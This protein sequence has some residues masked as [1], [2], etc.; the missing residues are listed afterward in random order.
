MDVHGNEC[1]WVVINRIL[2]KDGSL[3]CHAVAH[4]SAVV[5]DSDKYVPG[6]YHSVKKWDA[7]WEAGPHVNEGW[8]KSAMSKNPI[9][10][11]ILK[12]DGNGCHAIIKTHDKATGAMNMY[13]IY[14]VWG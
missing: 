11:G 14:A 13:E 3:R 1:G 6:D 12:G 10:A 4:W 8:R 7:V 2:P 9:H 5:H